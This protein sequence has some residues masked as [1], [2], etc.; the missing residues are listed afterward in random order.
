MKMK[1]IFQVLYIV[2]ATALVW[3]C[4]NT[5]E[6]KEMKTEVVAK[7]FPEP[8]DSTANGLHP[9]YPTEANLLGQ[10]YLPDPTDS[11]P[12]ETSSY[13]EFLADK[14]VKVENAAH[15][16]VQ[17]WELSGNMLIMTHESGDPIEK[18]RMVSDTLVVEAVSDTSVH[19]YHLHEPNF[20]MHLKKKK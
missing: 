11:T 20:L 4:G 17:K 2:A 6:K 19:Y 8:T 15:F 7:K 13:I 14:S 10:W 12:H 3:S 5:E 16:N 18:G 1:R 9:F